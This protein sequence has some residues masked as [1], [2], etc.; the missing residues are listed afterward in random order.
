MKSEEKDLEQ[1]KQEKMEE[2]M[3]EKESEEFPSEP[4]TVTDGNFE[5]VINKYPVVVIDFWAEWCAPCKAMGKVIK[6]LAN[7]YS[8]EIVFGKLNIDENPETPRKFQVSGIPTLLITKDGEPADKVV[9]MAPKERLNQR[10]SK[11]LD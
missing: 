11:Y 5:E 1:L 3:S 10:L 7:K 8:G 6:E 9:G 2:I 4:I